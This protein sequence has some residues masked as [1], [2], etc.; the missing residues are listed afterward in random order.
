[1]WGGDLMLQI[2]K[3][4]VADQYLSSTHI[5]GWVFIQS[6]SYWR[7]NLLKS[8]L[9]KTAQSLNSC[10]TWV[11]KIP[12]PYIPE[13]DTHPQCCQDPLVPLFILLVVSYFLSG[14]DVHLNDVISVLNTSQLEGFRVSCSPYSQVQNAL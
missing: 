4:L 3:H 8:V 6:N 5:N 12:T 13:P 2:L 14:T 1:M 11:L 9:S 10:P 7:F